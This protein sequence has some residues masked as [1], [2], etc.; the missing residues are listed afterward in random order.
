MEDI[1]QKVN[2]LV[3]V[4]KRSPELEDLR[5]YKQKVDGDQYMADLMK[6]YLK[7]Q[8][9]LETCQMLGNEVSD[10]LM[11]ECG[12]L[13]EEVQQMPDLVQFLGAQYNFMQLWD[14]IQRIMGDAISDIFDIEEDRVLN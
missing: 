11:E 3:D 5:F 12:R 14:D 8:M 6:R 7:K 1:Y 2:E 4:L 13:Y 9:E 10:E